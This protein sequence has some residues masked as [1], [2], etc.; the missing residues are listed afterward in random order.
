MTTHATTNTRAYPRTNQQN[1]E[2]NHNPNPTAKQRTVK[3]KKTG[4]GITVI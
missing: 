4:K 2:S 3:G 1:D